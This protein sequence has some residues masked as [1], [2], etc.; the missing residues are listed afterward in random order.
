[1]T[2]FLLSSIELKND[3]PEHIMFI[4]VKVYNL[5]T[6]RRG[7]RTDLK[8]GGERPSGIRDPRTGDEIL[9]PVYDDIDI[10]PATV[11]GHQTT[12]PGTDAASSDHDNAVV[13]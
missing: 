9:N 8:A 2:L 10:N 12:P 4:H 7:N 1:M 6:R 11:S 3:R 13:Q 5:F